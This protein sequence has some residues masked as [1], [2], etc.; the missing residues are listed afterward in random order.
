MP[1]GLEWLVEVTYPA[2]PEAGSTICWAGGQL[3]GGVFIVISDA[4]EA[5]EDGSPPRNM[6]RALVFMAVV[7]IAAVVPAMLLGVV[8]RVNMGRREVDKR[9]GNRG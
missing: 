2:S 9:L 3:L 6:G 5:G 1:V 4:L 7:A 8:G